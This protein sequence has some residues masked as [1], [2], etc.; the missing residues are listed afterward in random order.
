MPDTE[1][2]HPWTGELTAADLDRLGA[3]PLRRTDPATIGPYRV[4]ARLG[5]GGMGRLF[6]GRAVAADE[7]QSAAYTARDLVAVKVIRP[8][9]AEDPRFRR[10][11]ER[12]VE[13]V[14]RVHGR[15]TAG[16]LGSGFDEDEHLWMATAY[17]PGLSLDDAVRLDG[18]LPAPVVWRLAAEVGQAL[19]T[20]AAAGIVHRD[21]KPSNVLLAVDGVRVIDFGV[22][23]TADTSVLTMTGQQVGTP[24][25][26]SPEQASGRQVATASDVFSLG[27]L[28]ALTASGRAPFGEGSTGDVIHRL[29]YEPPNAEVV[30]RVAQT[31]P[32]LADLVRR[33]LD[34][35]PASRPSPQ[36][37]A[38]EARERDPAREWPGQVAEVIGGRA[39]WSGWT[40]AVS[41]TDQLTVLRR[42]APVRTLRQEAPK[43]RRGLAIGA[44]AAFVI[45]VAAAVVAF[46]V[47]GQGPSH[48]GKANVAVTRSAPPKPSPSALHSQAPTKHPA[49]HSSS[50]PSAATSQEAPSDPGGGG[51]TQPTAPR[52]QPEQPP[53]R[54]ITVPPPQPSAT[55]SRSEPW[56]SCNFYSGTALTQ[57]GDSGKRVSEVQ[58]I[59]QKRGYDIGAGGVDGQF[60][61]DTR[62]A[63]KRFQQRNGLQVDGQVG[64]ETWPALRG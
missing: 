61:N 57:Y 15:Y 11:F 13:A 23:H 62:A 14:G 17:V 42:G 49:P 33:C 30:D 52:Q 1:R 26:M 58:C 51:N 47:P 63:V 9:Y 10:R 36:Q 35:D 12:E 28:L 24:A 43:R 56:K 34:K 21:L 39:T 7:S 31:A 6:L 4:L 38:D 2:T 22:A 37:I 18:P 40:A 46:V 45:A 44:A 27:S 19:A 25:Y 41:P 32:A 60:G 8:E 20:V 55:P 59:L 54:I 16:L 5:S 64:A 3:E 50:R 53:T 48:G 29:I